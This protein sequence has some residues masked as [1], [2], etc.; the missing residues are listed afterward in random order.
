M[1]KIT[2]LSGLLLVAALSMASVWLYL[3]LKHPVN[4]STLTLFGNVDI[5]E[6]Q[7]AFNDNGR[8]ISMLTLEGAIVHKGEL[9]AT[10]DDVPY[11]AELA[12]ARAQ[13]ASLAQTLARLKAGSRPEEIAQARATMEALAATL[14]NAK[15]VYNRKVILAPTSAISKQQ[16]DD[17]KAAYEAAAQQHEAARQA[18]MLAVKGPREEDINAAE[19]N[20]RAAQ[21]AV[22]SAEKKHADTK[23]YAP[24]DGIVESR[25]LEPGDMAAPNTPVYTI[26]LRQPLWVRAYVAETDLGKIAY[27][28]RAAITTDSFPG[29]VYHGWVGY[30]SPTAEFTPKS[31]ETATLRTALVY[32]TR[33]YVCDSRNQ[34]RLGMPATVKV[35]LSPVA[36]DAPQAARTGCGAGDAANP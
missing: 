10:M 11:V 18:Y 35:D 23:L 6:V 31:V 7:L 32:Q 22:A 8:V 4:S 15:I 21:A 2:W 17:A 34:L 33:I 29:S 25:I 19:A 13:A 16:Y 30:I 14:A 3:V 27:G 20:L 1:T 24:E 5:R 9:L 12:Q 28:M 26:A 36:P